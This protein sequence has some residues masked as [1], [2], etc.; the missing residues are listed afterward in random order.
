MIKTPEL[1]KIRKVSEKS[2][3]IGNFLDWLSS[4]EGYYIAEYIKGGF[5]EEKLVTINLDIEQFLAKYFKINLVKA[6][7]ER[8]AILDNLKQ[9][10][11]KR[12][13]KQ[14]KRI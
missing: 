14:D 3:E 12:I 11:I 7:K 2:Q 10:G 13:R 8:Q 6:E 9:D 1:D 4:K 5:D